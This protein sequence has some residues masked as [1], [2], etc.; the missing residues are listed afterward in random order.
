VIGNGSEGIE[1]VRINWLQLWHAGP[2]ALLL[3]SSS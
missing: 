1:N 3:S 2:L